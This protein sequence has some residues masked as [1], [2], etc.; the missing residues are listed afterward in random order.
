MRAE[1]N[2]VSKFNVS[3]H[4]NNK[5]ISFFVQKKFLWFYW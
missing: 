4:G 3:H 5:K 1:R 2:K